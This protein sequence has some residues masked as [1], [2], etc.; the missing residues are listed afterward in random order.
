MILD[1]ATFLAMDEGLET[2]NPQS[3]AALSDH[4]LLKRVL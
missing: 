2:Y 4:H 3:I 1:E